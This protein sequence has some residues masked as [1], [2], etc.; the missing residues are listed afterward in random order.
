MASAKDQVGIWQCRVSDG[1]VQYFESGPEAEF[2]AKDTVECGFQVI[3]Q[4]IR[5]PRTQREFVAFMESLTA[6]IVVKAA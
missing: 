5:M 4:F 2:F 6:E 1:T 3:T